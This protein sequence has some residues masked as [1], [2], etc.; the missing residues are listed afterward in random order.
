[1]SAQP[2]KWSA[3]FDG[4]ERVS[5]SETEGEA[6]GEMECQI[7]RD[8]ETGEQV[9]YRVAQMVNGLELLQRQR[10]QSIGENIIEQIENDLTDEMGSEES[11][12]S[13]AD[14]DAKLL[15]EMVV[16]F[17][18]ANA[19]PQWWTVDAK[20]EQTRTYIAGSNDSQE[21]GAA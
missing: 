4:D 1:M 11:P 20:T 9:E 21:G 18:A 5:I 15:G 7:D 17:I 16:T 14:G 2:K 19:T 6:I 13:F 3:Y 10:A 12:L 8:F